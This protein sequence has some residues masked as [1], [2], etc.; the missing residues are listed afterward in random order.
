MALTKLERMVLQKYR[1]YLQKPPTFTD[2][3]MAAARRLFV[4]AVFG[5]FARFYLYDNGSQQVA[6]F[7]AGV[8]VGAIFRA[9]G[10]L[11]VLSKAFPITLQILDANRI[12]ELLA[13]G[14]SDAQ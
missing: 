12:N 13:Q 4:I 11:R 2:L 5:A 7:I 1:A 14:E 6:F 3:F 9:I 8:A 10:Q